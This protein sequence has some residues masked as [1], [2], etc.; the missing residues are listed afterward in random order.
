[1]VKVSMSQWFLQA[2]I[3]ILFCAPLYYYSNSPTHYYLEINQAE[4]K[5]A[6]KHAAKRKEKCRKRTRKEL[7]KL[8]PNMRRAQECTRERS[9]LLVE[10]LLDGNLLAKKSFTPPGLH[11]DGSAYVYAKFPVPIGSHHLSIRM[12]DSNRDEGFDYTEEKQF[13]FKSGASLVIGFDG[14]AKHFIF[15]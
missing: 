13:T 9:L 1:M 11:N 14:A 2:L 15:Y 5:L 3:Y 8:A 7:A 10:L 6:F 12:R 4:V